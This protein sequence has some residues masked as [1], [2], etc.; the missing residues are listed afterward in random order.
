VAGTAPRP[1]WYIASNRSR[2]SAAITAGCR[3]RWEPSESARDGGNGEFRPGG[4][5][6]GP[7]SVDTLGPVHLSPART[8]TPRRPPT[9][10]APS[11]EIKPRVRTWST[12]AQ[13]TRDYTIAC[14]GRCKSDNYWRLHCPSLPGILKELEY[15]TTGSR[16]FDTTQAGT[17]PFASS[18]WRSVPVA[19]GVYRCR[20]GDQRSD[21]WIFRTRC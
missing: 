13:S 5:W 2:F 20:C 1:R 21:Y 15:E 19:P 4:L 7:I 11:G 10:S 16:R 8:P 3:A 9:G 12:C 18:S 17:R 6:N 14:N